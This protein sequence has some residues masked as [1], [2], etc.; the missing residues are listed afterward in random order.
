M[1]VKATLTQLATEGNAAKTVVTRTDISGGIRIDWFVKGI[2][3]AAAGA[4]TD[5]TVAVQ[6]LVLNQPADKAYWTE[7]IKLMVKSANALTAKSA[8]L[9]LGFTSDAA[10]VL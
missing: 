7:R 10:A 1:I 6:L 8:R 9:E 4:K 5:K 3:A 2:A